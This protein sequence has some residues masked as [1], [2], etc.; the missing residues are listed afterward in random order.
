MQPA[1]GRAAVVAGWKE[2]PLAAAVAVE[3]F[4]NCADVADAG[5][6]VAVVVVPQCY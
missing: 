5:L 6:A 1:A 3:I 4:V 2:R